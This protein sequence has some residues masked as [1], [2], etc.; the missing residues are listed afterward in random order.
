MKRSGA[1]IGVVLAGAVLA[2]GG[3]EKELFPSRIERSPFERYQRLHGKYRPQTET[4]E[5]GGEEP[6]IRERLKPLESQ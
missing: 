4:N 6:A 3:C 5:Y 1:W 2:A